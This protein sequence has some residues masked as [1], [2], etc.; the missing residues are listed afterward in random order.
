MSTACQRLRSIALDRHVTVC[1]YNKESLY[2]NQSCINY[3]LL[4]I[5]VEPLNITMATKIIG[6]VHM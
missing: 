1:N 4:S 6:E 5:T 3:L 2:N